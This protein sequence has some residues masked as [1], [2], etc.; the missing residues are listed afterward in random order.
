[1]NL[2]Q[3]EKIQSHC[4]LYIGYNGKLTCNPFIAS[5]THK[6]LDL[7]MINKPFNNPKL[8]FLYADFLDHL[9]LILE[10]FQNP[11]VLVLHNS[12]HNITEQHVQIFLHPKI[13]K[14]FTQN[15][16]VDHPKL[17]PLPIGIANSMW[18]HGNTK[19]IDEQILNKSNKVYF[20]F[21][22]NTNYHE[23]LKC[24]EEIKKWIPFTSSIPFEQYISVLSTYEFCICPIGNGV[25]THRLWEALYLKVVPIVLD[26]PFYR[27]LQK[28][29]DLPIIILSSWCEL[30]YKELNY[31]SYDFSKVPYLENILNQISNI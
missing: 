17:F 18:K 20:Q 4:D 28:H 9:P 10:S 19:L 13:I 23:R 7:E 29:F 25:D 26:H 21:S 6:H 24:Y 22:F 15:L 5:Q 2:I 27:V 1:M 8:V 31:S 11:F 16:C 12:D 3:G 14:V 30:Y